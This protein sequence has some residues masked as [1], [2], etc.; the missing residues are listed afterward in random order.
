MFPTAL[1]LTLAPQ[2]EEILQRVRV[3]VQTRPTFE[4]E[5][6][7][8]TFRVMASDYLIEVLFSE[9]IRDLAIRAPGIRLEILASNENS[10][11]LFH[12][13]ELDLVAV[14]EAR[15]LVNHPRTLLFEETFSCIA[16]SSNTEVDEM[17]S[18]ARWL[19]MRHVVV[20]VARD[21]PTHFERWFSEQEA[22]IR[23]QRR[24]DIIAPSFGVVPHLVIG[25]QRIATMQTRHARL[26][27]KL[28]PLRVLEPPVGFPFMR[29]YLQWPRLLDSDPAIRWLVELLVNFGGRS[30]RDVITSPPPSLPTR[31]LAIAGR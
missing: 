30:K 15:T 26:Y 4:P 5:T 11:E 19:K 20:Q 9:V 18:M 23:T 28:L 24:V 10:F 6:A 8:R 3:T 17:L 16:W 2:V 31:R 1:A 25:T 21:Q 13:G 29:E 12:N 14:P 22:A 7:Q 27:E